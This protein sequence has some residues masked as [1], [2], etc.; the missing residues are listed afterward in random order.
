M[1]EGIS[2]PNVACPCGRT[3]STW[4]KV[5][6]GIRTITCPSCGRK[7]TLCKAD[8]D[9]NVSVLWQDKPNLL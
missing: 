2:V 4:R 6:K 7:F 5:R 3:I 9:I 8:K 1:E